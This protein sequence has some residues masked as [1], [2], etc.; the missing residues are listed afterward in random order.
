MR[1]GRKQL[2]STGDLTFAVLIIWLIVFV[3]A[4]P[5]LVALASFV[6]G[7]LPLLNRIIIDLVYTYF[8][9][10]VISFCM[11][12]QYPGLM[13]LPGIAVAALALVSLFGV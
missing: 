1:A 6:L 11:R 12:R 2:A 3:I 4:A 8:A 7:P 10:L 13:W 5:P 9:L